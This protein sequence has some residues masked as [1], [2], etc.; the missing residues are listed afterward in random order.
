MSF[1]NP[2]QA[3]VIDQREG[4]LLVLA[5]AGTGKTRVMAERLAR[6]VED[7]IDPARALCVTFTNR[8][9]HEM[10]ERVKQRLAGAARNVRLFT[11]HGLCA[12]I[13]RLEADAVGL[14]R[15]FVIY[16]EEDANE[17]L[18]GV[19][20]DEEITANGKQI[21]E[22]LEN[23]SRT[24][25]GMPIE[26]LV[27]GEAAVPEW[28]RDDPDLARAVGK[29]HAALAERHALDFGDLIYHVRC[30]LHRVPERSRRWQ[31]RFDWVQV[32]EV[33]DT[34]FSEY[35]VLR[36]LGR[37]ARGMAFFG[38][39]DQT[40]YE[41]RGSNPAHVLAEF[42][43]DFAPLRRLELRENYRATRSLLDL[44]DRF[45]QSFERRETVLTP[46]P[47]LAAGRG[48][49]LHH[50]ETPEEEAQWIAD[51]IVADRADLGRIGILARTR[52][53][54]A[55]VSKALSARGV[56]H[57][58]V[59]EFEFF[60]RQEI[61]DALARV[62][63]LL[64]PHDGGAMH[65][66][67]LRPA[68]GVGEATLRRLRD[69]AETSGLRLVDLARQA[70]HEAGEPFG[71]LARAWHAGEVV[72]LDVESTGLATGEDEVVE[73]AAI[74][75]GADGEHETLHR[76]L[77]PGRPV[78]T[79]VEVHGLTDEF[80]AR[81]GGD[82]ATVYEE[83]GAFL[84]GRHVVGHNVRFDLAILGSHSGRCARPLER[85]PWD[86]TLDLA[87]RFVRCERYDLASLC[88]EL[89][90]ETQP[91]HRALDDTR[92]TVELLAALLPHVERGALARSAAVARHGS[93]FAGLA[94][95]FESL[96]S[97]VET[98]RPAAAL[99]RALEE[100][101]L[102]EYYEGDLRRSEYLDELI[103][104]F[105][106][107]DDARLDCASALETVMQTASLARNV[108]HL[109]EN[110]PRIPVLTVHQAKGLEFDTV[111]VA[112]LAEGEFPSFFAAKEGRVE[113]ER[114]LFYV[115][116]TRPRRAIYLSSYQINDW[117]YRKGPSRFLQPLTPA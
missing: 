46:A 112:G 49:V 75:C 87:R 43:R 41:W 108:D 32:D 4:S 59:E 89:G 36:M 19:L 116:L 115:A 110:D 80:L 12:R 84:G 91:T 105:D 50:A 51:R 58:T 85:P 83:L 10:R 64:N 107:E 106:R 68:S 48:A 47:A 65:R 113:E 70:T 6:A 74:R 55:A 7:G 81:E 111:F 99:T 100:S 66:V 72:V 27:A 82:A 62:K 95:Q 1:P 92:A 25:S 21:R 22:L 39:V 2:E 114:R 104:F 90:V 78:G 57:V 53:R 61:K 103:S 3:A 16:D 67:L 26:Q 79:S 30:M 40:I 117:G 54:T 17:L 97:D 86:D 56:E 15:D 33:Q 29:Y 42:E 76:Y 45:A 8:A 60:R 96:R 77:R 101:G 52:R 71:A 9:A 37:N 14:A 28:L 24:K 94:R 20:R 69:E 102:R 98:L 88:K 73:I 13:L 18:T 44:A 34:H 109:A 63:L 38:D 5:P 31:E 11:F 23:V 35:D 93:A